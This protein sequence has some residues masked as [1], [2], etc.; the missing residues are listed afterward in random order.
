MKLKPFIM[1]AAI[2]VFLEVVVFNYRSIMTFALKEEPASGYV[3]SSGLVRGEDDEIIITNS[4]P[5]IVISNIDEHVSSICADLEM[6]YSSTLGSSELYDKRGRTVRVAI[7]AN[8]AANALEFKLGERVI[9]TDVEASKYMITHLAG[10]TGTI[11]L[12]ILEG[13]DSRFR[14]RKFSYNA[15]IPFQFSI[16]RILVVGLLLGTLY[17]FRP[18]SGVYKIVFDTADYRQK[19]VSIVAFSALTTLYLMLVCANPYFIHPRWEHHY[20][21]QQL[22]ESFEQGKLYLL[23]EPDA[24]LLAMDNPYD[25]YQRNHLKIKFLW[26][27]VLYNGKYYVYFGVLP[28]LLF[29]YPW[30]M[31]TGGDFSTFVGIFLCGVALIAGFFYLYQ[32][33]I[34][35]WFRKT[36]YIVYLCA[37]VLSAVGCGA[38]PAMIR[39]DFYSLPILMAEALSVWGF[40]L[41]VA[42]GLYKK[43]RYLLAGSLCM[44]LVAGCRPQQLA[45]SFIAIPLFYREVFR[46][47]SLFS[48]KSVGRTA[49]FILPY[50]V[51]AIGV[52]CYNAARFD[53]PFDFGANYNLT[54]NDMT[55]RGFVAGRTF[56]GIFAFLFQTPKT[57]AVFP[58]IE[59]VNVNTSYLGT[60]I[61]EGMCGGLLVCNLFLLPVFLVFLKAKGLWCS[62]CARRITLAALLMTLVIIIADTQMAGILPR[63]IMDFGWAL[64]MAASICVFALVQYAGRLKSTAMLFGVRVFL[65]IA[66]VQ[67]IVY[68]FLRTFLQGS[69]SVAE[70][71]PEFYYT[72]LHLIAFWV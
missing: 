66:F 69:D 70:S 15:R 43:S 44:A 61:T 38:L 62:G 23:T 42:F 50:I 67:G 35:R 65:M 9:A 27:R 57:S 22:A 1:I 12:D 51:A 31:L 58:F 48:K 45:M 63:Y 16:I 6:V 24:G 55:Q 34:R 11:R 59:Q 40:A 19:I 14:I 41:W 36:P 26:D 18:G 71:N 54:T 10:E 21:Y 60:T 39:P 30:H 56:L 4:Q 2:T 3:L 52:M 5:S 72:V 8:D 46:E 32:C 64:F 20:Q 29:Y 68:N 47:R 49:A 13:V 7:Y 17:C 25:T 28:E 53:S 33:I 37:V